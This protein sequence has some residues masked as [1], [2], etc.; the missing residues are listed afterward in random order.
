MTLCTLYLIGLL[1]TLPGLMAFLGRW[2]GSAKE[3]DEIITRMNEAHHPTQHDITATNSSASSSPSTHLLITS[4]PLTAWTTC[5]HFVAELLPFLSYQPH[6][7]E[8]ARYYSLPN[9]IDEA[10][11]FFVIAIIVEFI[12]AH[13]KEKRRREK[14]MAVSTRAQSDGSCVENAS[15]SPT[16]SNGNDH[17]SIKSSTSTPPKRDPTPSDLAADVDDRPIFRWN[18][19]IN[20][21]SLGMLQQMMHVSLFVRPLMYVPYIYV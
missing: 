6:L 1:T 2:S 9:W 11:P 3:Y 19:S 13:G 10:V 7:P 8:P 14:K 5:Y 21:M 18:D 17:A 20:S 4:S 16:M 15:S 12:I